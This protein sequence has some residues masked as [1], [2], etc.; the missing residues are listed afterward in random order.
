LRKGRALVPGKQLVVF[1][2]APATHPAPTAV[3]EVAPSK[4]PVPA[5]LTL[6]TAKS[7]VAA[8]T[9]KMP[10]ET[11]NAVEEK[12]PAV[13]VASKEVAAA[14]PARSSAGSSMTPALEAVEEAESAVATD[15]LPTEYVVRKGDYLS[16]IAEVRG[17]SVKQLMEWNKLTSITVSPGQKLVFA[18]PVE[19]AEAPAKEEVAAAAPTQQKPPRPTKTTATQQIATSEAIRKVH[20]VQAGDT[21]YNI[22]RRYQGVTVEQLKRLNNLTTDEV[23]PGQKLIVA[24]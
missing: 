18:A 15:S 5:H 11:P 19:E 2:P 12:A 22:S 24:R 4:L 8:R 1:V 6:P 21:L 7:A 10:A 13:A 23:K 3:A 20:L 16:R 14:R 9:T 17:L